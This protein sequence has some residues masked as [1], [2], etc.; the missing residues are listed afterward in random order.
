MI[1]F[2]LSLAKLDISN[3]SKTNKQMITNYVDIDQIGVCVCLSVFYKAHATYD[4]YL[5]NR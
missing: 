4:P 3:V 2:D 1:R 5:D